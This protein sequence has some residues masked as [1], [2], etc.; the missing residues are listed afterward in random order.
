MGTDR[1][2]SQF[3]EWLE[4]IGYQPFFSGIGFNA[5]CPNLLIQ[6][7]LR[8]SIEEAYRATGRKVH[9]VGHSLGGMIARAAACQM[10]DRV[11][12]IITLGAPFHSVCVHPSVLRTV[13]VVRQQILERN[14]DA[15]LPSCYT[16]ACT[17]DFLTSL[18]GKFPKR[19][20]QTAIYAKTDGMVDWHACM[21]G[22]PAID[23]EVSATH[24][25]MVFSPI[26]YD[27]VARRLASK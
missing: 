24:L 25:G 1:Y 15:V 4:R 5:E 2:L 11:E 6:L 27:V 23:V 19:V 21:T 26:V 18:L 14:G 8:E 9:L 13:E 12:S 3:R 16:G 22:D 7:R 10:S 17:C 20:R